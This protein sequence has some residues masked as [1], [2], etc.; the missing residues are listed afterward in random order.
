MGSM[1]T[2]QALSRGSKKVRIIYTL[3]EGPLL[4]M[5]PTRGSCRNFRG[6]SVSLFLMSKVF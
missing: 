6:L 3:D 4:K 5:E 1:C 2:E